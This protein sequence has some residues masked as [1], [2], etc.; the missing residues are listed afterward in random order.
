MAGYYA[1]WWMGV[2]VSLGCAC[3]TY[4]SYGGPPGANLTGDIYI[5]AL[6]QTDERLEVDESKIPGL[7]CD[8]DSY[9]LVVDTEKIQVPHIVNRNSALVES[10][11]H[12]EA[13][14]A[15]SGPILGL[16]LLLTKTSNSPGAN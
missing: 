3:M 9:R 10:E 13:Q 12:P 4:L 7:N 14:T 8:G 15:V 1:L 2:P 16:F 5:P 11:F 6:V